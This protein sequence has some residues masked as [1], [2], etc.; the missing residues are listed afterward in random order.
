[1][2]ERSGRDPL[3]AAL[4]GLQPAAAFDRDRLMFAAGQAAATPRHGWLWPSATA[5][6]VFL[7]LGLATALATRPGPT[8]TVRIVYQNEVKPAPAVPRPEVSQPDLPPSAAP[9]EPDRMVADGTP[10]RRGADYLQMR[11]QV[12]RFGVE[13]LPDA[14]PLSAGDRMPSI[15]SLLE[16]PKKRS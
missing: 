3:E 14:P 16:P 12:L 6:L 5:A 9:S 4:A 7:S 15:D 13:S 1:M 10:P 11:R 2:S 8:E